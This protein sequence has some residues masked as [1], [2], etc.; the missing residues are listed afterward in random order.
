[1]LVTSIS[2]LMN[3]IAPPYL[4]QHQLPALHPATLK[5][6]H[7]RFSYLQGYNLLACLQLLASFSLSHSLPQLLA[8]L[9]FGGAWAFGIYTPDERQYRFYL[10]SALLWVAVPLLLAYYLL[11]H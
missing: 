5:Q 3:P 8:G 1:L 10:A 2:Q 9:A 6:Q 11:H 7:D 4:H